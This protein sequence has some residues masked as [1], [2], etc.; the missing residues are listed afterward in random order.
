MRRLIGGM[1]LGVGLTL[2]I[3]LPEQKAKVEEV[4]E[5]YKAELYECHMAYQETLRKCYEDR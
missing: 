1:L 5:V 4:V 2:L 3:V